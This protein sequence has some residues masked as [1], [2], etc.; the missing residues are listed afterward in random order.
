MDTQI[1]GSRRAEHRRAERTRTRGAAG[2]PGQPTAEWQQTVRARVLAELAEFVQRRSVESAV[3]PAVQ[4]V[5]WQY[6]GG[7]KCVRSAFMYAGWL[8]GATEDDTALRAS[9]ALELL[10]AFALLQDDVMDESARRRGEPT[11]HRRLADR[12]R[13]NGLPGCPRR[14]GES[15]A[16]LLGDICLIWAEQMLRESGMDEPA[17]ARVR[18]HYDRMRIELA[19]GQFADLSNDIRSAPTLDAVLAIARAKSG[20][21]T[22]KW[23]LVLGAAMADCDRHVTAALAEYG[24]AIGEAFQLRDDILGVYGLPEVTGKPDNDI[25]QHKASTVIVAATEMAGSRLHRELCTLLQAPTLGIPEVARVR[26]LIT[27]TG[28][29]TRIEAMIDNRVTE[30]RHAL[31]A[32]P[33]PEDRRELLDGMAARCTV[34]EF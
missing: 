26:A 15:A 17:L 34:R 25:A 3:R 11:A 10:H 31:A 9:A 29:P 5:L 2:L 7:G 16:T 33:L 21:Y 27:A 22:V 23:P 6:V 20:D 19:L 30:A 18:P 32:A 28:A 14:F 12:H 13:R 24:R 1:V 4:H 8:C